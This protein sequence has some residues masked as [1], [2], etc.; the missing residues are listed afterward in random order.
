M[1]NSGLTLILLLLIAISCVIDPAFAKNADPDQISYSDVLM[2]NSG[3]CDAGRRAT[4]QGLGT[5]KDDPLALK[6]LDGTEQVS[7]DSAALINSNS[8]WSEWNQ[9]VDSAISKS[10]SN[11]EERVAADD[12]LVVAKALFNITD[13]GKIKIVY[14]SN[15]SLN[16]KFESMIRKALESL[17]GNPVLRFPESTDK[18]VIVK[19]GRFIQNFGISKLDERAR[20]GIAEPRP[21][22]R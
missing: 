7:T 17:E 19:S 14:L 1:R 9:K 3:G 16:P 6:Y 18:K 20:F 5:L 8:K 21:I 12:K 10:F 4:L 13:Q 15:Y 11:L 2:P 22:I